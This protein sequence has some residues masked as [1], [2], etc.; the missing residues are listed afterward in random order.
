MNPSEFV[1]STG[2]SNLSAKS[3]VRNVILLRAM[4]LLPVSV[5]W[6]RKPRDYEEQSNRVRAVI[7][8]DL[9]I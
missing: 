8:N 9:V 2:P 3:V 7:E 5:I 4:S 1:L 6:K